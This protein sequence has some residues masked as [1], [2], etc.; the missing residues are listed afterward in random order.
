MELRDLRYFVAVADYHGFS[1]AADI[2]RISQPALSRQVK[3]LEEELGLRL[4]DRV[5]RRTILTAAG[6][7]LLERAR[8]LLYESDSIKGRA[9][10]LAGGSRGL[11]RLG[12][13]P[14]AYESFVARLLVDFRRASPQVEV[15]LVEEGAANLL[16][17]VSSG[18]IH[19]AVAS[20][21]SGT[22]LAGRPLFPFGIVAFLPR[23]H[24][25]SGVKAIDVAQ[26]VPHP[27]L[28]MRRTFLNRQIFDAACHAAHIAPKV[29]LESNSAQS[30]MAL[31]ESTQGI[32]ILP[33]TVRL[34]NSK[35]TIVPLRHNGRPLGLWMYVIWEER[36]YLTPAAEAFIDVAYRGTR[37]KYPGKRFHFEQLGF[38]PPPVN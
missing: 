29:M 15:T 24:P 32:A 22:G 26:L 4:F 16:E 30:L 6:S 2:L 34:D 31:A 38:P 3:D 1:R 8:A 36:R 20:L 25:L 7:D 17:A 10:D 35:N 5:G 18:A 13:T 28:L 27:L 23:G 14:H 11:L 21:P 19:V 33:S 12:A 9:S 37:Q